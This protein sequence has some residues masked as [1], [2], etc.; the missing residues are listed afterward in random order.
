MLPGLISLSGMH[1][2]GFQD[3]IPTPG[4]FPSYDEI[5]LRNFF[6]GNCLD[7]QFYGYSECGQ[8]DFNYYILDTEISVLRLFACQA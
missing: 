4:V 5:R 1:N 2:E 7:L 8:Q 6:V 3:F